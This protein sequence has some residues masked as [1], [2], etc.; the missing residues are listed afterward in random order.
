MKR[1]L[2]DE[3]LDEIVRA[4]KRDFEA[5]TEVHVSWPLNLPL[6]VSGE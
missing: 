6:D 2:T 5:V 4:V 1:E 3:Q